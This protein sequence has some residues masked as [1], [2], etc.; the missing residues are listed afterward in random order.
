MRPD[1][2]WFPTSRAERVAWFHNFATVFT[3]IGIG[4]GFSQAEIDSVNADNAIVKASANAIASVRAFDRAV[5][6]FERNALSGRSTGATLSFPATPEFAMPPMVKN[7][8]FERL[9]RL[10]RRIRLA[11]GYNEDVGV[12]LGIVPTRSRA[13]DVS[14]VVPSFRMSTS[15]DKYSFAVK[16][17]KRGYDGFRVEYR[18]NMTNEWESTPTFTRSPAQIRVKPTKFGE[19]ELLHVRIRMVKADQAVG[20]YSDEQTVVILP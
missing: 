11:N 17:A 13:I 2:R 9:E 12:Q 14:Q 10:V 19:P 18:R 1:Q 8:V 3:D 7:G 6:A 5:I 20:K 4:L 15:G 16:A